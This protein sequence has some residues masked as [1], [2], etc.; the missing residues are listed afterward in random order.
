MRLTSA[1]ALALAVL[2][3]CCAVFVCLQ[4]GDAVN[5]LGAE[6]MQLFMLHSELYQLAM[7]GGK[8]GS[9]KGRKPGAAAAADGSS[10]V[11][12]T[13][14]VLVVF[15]WIGC[16]LCD[17]IVALRTCAAHYCSQGA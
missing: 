7:E 14:A 6:L 9:K 1:C 11:L 16:V 5:K 12:T 2:H 8:G 10:Q 3:V 13:S 17:R 4:D 15:L